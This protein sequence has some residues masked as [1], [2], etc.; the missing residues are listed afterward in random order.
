MKLKKIHNKIKKV[1]SS[2]YLR[3]KR[4]DPKEPTYLDYVRMEEEEKRR[5]YDE[6]IR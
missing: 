1:F 2:K 6:Y 5:M 3:G 4:S